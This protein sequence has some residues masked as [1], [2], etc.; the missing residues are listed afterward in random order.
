MACACVLTTQVTRSNAPP[1]GHKGRARRPKRLRDGRYWVRTSDLL[2]VRRGRTAALEAA[3][4]ALESE[5][6]LARS[7][8]RAARIAV[9]YRGLRSIWA[10]EAAWC[11]F[12]S[13]DAHS[14]MPLLV[15]LA[16]CASR[17]RSRRRLA[18]FST[19]VGAT[20]EP[21]ARRRAPASRPEEE[22]AGAAPSLSQ[23][24]ETSRGPTRCRH[25]CF[26]SAKGS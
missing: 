13:A 3:F 24:A 12:I 7:R 19:D 23:C 9:D 25:Y 11:P 20:R 17:K 14:L 6:R 10:P 18:A 22:R 16:A 26:S 15:R 8:P 5:R 1:P 2:L 21:I 4:S